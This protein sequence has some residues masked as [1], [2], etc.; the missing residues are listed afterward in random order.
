M[1]FTLA[2]VPSAKECCGAETHQP[3][4]HQKEK[5]LIYPF[6]MD[7]LTASLKIRDIIDLIT[8]LQLAE[9]TDS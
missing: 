4:A 6:G 1:L 7:F 9:Q 5:Q 3:V 2:Q 8:V